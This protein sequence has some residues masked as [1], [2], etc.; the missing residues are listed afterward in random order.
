MPIENANISNDDDDELNGILE[1]V[2]TEEDAES[3]VTITQP[4]D[5]SKIRVETKQLSLD[6]LLSRI[7]NEEIILQ[8]DFQRKE[9]WKDSARSRLIESILIRIPLPAFYMDATDDERWLVVDGQQRLSTLRKFVIE[10]SLSLHGLEFLGEFK[11]FHFDQLPRP[12]QRR[13]RETNVTVYLIERGTPSA[14]KINIFKR[15]NTGG[16]PLSPQEIRHALN[17]A[18]VTVM[19]KELSESLEFR[20]ATRGKI[21][22][23][24][25]ADREYIVRFF[26]FLLTRPADYNAPEIDSFLNE[27]MATINKLS[28]EERTRLK[29]RFLRAMRICR[30]VLGKHAFRKRYS[31]DGRLKPINKALFEAWSVNLESLSDSEVTCLLERKDQLWNKFIHLMGD[32]NFEQS[33]T[34]GTGDVKRV[35]LRFS[36]IQ[37][38]IKETLA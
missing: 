17:G 38:L 10:Q 33:V 34:Q 3:E 21:P 12:F 27:T 26:S 5:P 2:E 14:V 29:N 37:L 11:D 13:I 31:L 4:F 28:L 1:E 9:V 6:T 15:I 22:T 36:S 20:Q 35:K 25:M 32:R 7:E 19:L 23:D 24:R 16:L 30:E 8:P 18:P